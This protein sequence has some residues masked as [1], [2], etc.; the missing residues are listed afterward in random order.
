MRDPAEQALIERCRT[1]SDEAFREFVDRYK[2]VVYGVV[3]RTIADPSRADDLAQE[4]FLRAHRGLAS[5]RGESSV[6]TWLFRITRNVCVE[7]RDRRR[8]ERSLDDLDERGRRFFEPGAP[9]RAFADIELRDR[10]GKALS[11]LPAAARFLVSA[12]YLSGRKYE[13]LAQALNLPIG[14]VKTHLHRAKR[15]L[16]ALLEVE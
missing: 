16:R 10:L 6:A 5:F 3:L 12:H 1:G 8:F 7:V 2:A 13:D 9:D 14:T 11:Q 4:V 15:R